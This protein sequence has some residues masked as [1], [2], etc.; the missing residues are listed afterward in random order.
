MTWMSLVCSLNGQCSGICGEVSYRDE[1]LTLADEID[2]LK[3]NDDDD[4]DSEYLN[5]KHPD[6]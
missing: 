5:F 2:D 4:N 1:C 6:R 3:I